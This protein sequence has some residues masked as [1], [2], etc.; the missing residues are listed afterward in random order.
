MREIET[1]LPFFDNINKQGRFKPYFNAYLK[2]WLTP[3]NRLPPFQFMGQVD[4]LPMIEF[5]LINIGTGAIADY[6]TYF[7]TNVTVV[8]LD[9]TN[10]YL[11]LGNIDVP[12]IDEGRYYLYAK[13]TLDGNDVEWWSDVFTICGITGE[14]GY[15]KVSETDYLLIASGDKLITR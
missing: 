2:E 13:T 8:S 4:N 3:S 15:L 5:K 1:G 12:V 11:H 9:I 10:R 14:I 7:N 6:L